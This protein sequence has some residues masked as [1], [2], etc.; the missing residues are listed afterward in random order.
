MNSIT[1]TGNLAADAKLQT[2]NEKEVLNFTL[3]SNDVKDEKG[4][5]FQCTYWRRADNL[6]QYL[7]KGKKIA[8][9]GYIRKI[10][11]V[12]KDKTV[13]VNTCVQ[14]E[15]LELLRSKKDEAKPE[16]EESK[17][18][19]PIETSKTQSEDLPF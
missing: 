6:V 18:N 9:S 10:E 14:V 15:R 1:I 2:I 17:I 3:I 16:P 19:P 13:Y 8:V 7:T 12:Q 5:K 4:I 11:G